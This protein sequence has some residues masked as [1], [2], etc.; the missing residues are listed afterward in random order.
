MNDTELYG[1][2]NDLNGKIKSWWDQDIRT[3]RENDIRN[4]EKNIIWYSDEGHREREKRSTQEWTLLFLPHPY[5][6]SAGS[7]DAFPEMYCWD[8]YFINHGLL[9]HERF[10]L[11]RNHLVNHLYMIERFGMVLN[12]NRTYYTTRSQTPLLAADVWRY[13]RCTQDKD[14]LLIAYPLLK[15]EYLTYWNADHH[16]TPTGLATNRDL[17][18]PSLRP[19]LAAEAEIHDFS[20]CF[21]G[22]V[23]KCNPLQTN[24]A[25]TRYAGT[26]ASIANEIGRPEEEAIWKKDE[27]MRKEQINRLCW[28]DSNNFYFDYQFERGEK[29]PYWSLSAYWTLWADIADVH[30]AR[31]L[32][33]HLEKFEH[34]FGL[35]QT[36]KRYPSPHPEFEWVQFEYPSGWPPMQ[37]I[38]VEALDRYG[39]TDTAKR[40]ARS[41]LT[42]MIEQ[43]RITGKLWE[44]YNVVKGNLSFPRERYTVPP[45]HGW[46]SAAVVVLGEYI[47]GD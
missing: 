25:L 12:G 28:D 5:I 45:F 47:F 46:T 32:V 37:M 2:W 40:I 22:D 18:D 15:K 16:R 20:P 29:L 3:A 17:G 26:L 39:Y 41:Y 6:S 36:D 43:Y 21:E 14:M 11:I 38:V 7:E 33:K 8:I 27:N 34:R 23:R 19:E 13:Y 44:K 31:A 4:P 42:L 30:Q 10:D 35:V 1:Y 24:A 9:L